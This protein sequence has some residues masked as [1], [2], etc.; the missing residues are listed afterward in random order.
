[1]FQF[2]FKVAHSTEL[3]L[4]KVFNDIFVALDKGD[5]VILV[6][7]DISAAFDMIDHEILIS[8]LENLEALKAGS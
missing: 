4:L 1:M 3:A 7:L 8:R 2:G 6:L 5:C